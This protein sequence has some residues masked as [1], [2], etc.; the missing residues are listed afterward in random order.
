MTYTKV[1]NQNSS[2]TKHTDQYTDYTEEDNELY[3]VDEDEDGDFIVAENEDFLMVRD[4]ITTFTKY[5]DTTS[6]YGEISIGSYLLTE[7][8]DRLVTEDLDL[9][10]LNTGGYY[11]K[12]ADV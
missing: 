5:S 7:G 11:T 2:Y 6:T 8:G 3:L 4:I 9:V 12:V 10:V 1:S